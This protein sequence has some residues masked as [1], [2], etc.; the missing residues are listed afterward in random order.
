[1]VCPDRNVNEVGQSSNPY[2]LLNCLP[3]AVYNND[4]RT[5]DYAGETLTCEGDLVPEITIQNYG[6]ITLTTLSIEVSVNG[7]PVSTTPWSGN[8]TTYATDNITLPVL[9]G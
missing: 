5:F 3:P 2:S 1:M 6:L 4:V 7:S 8:L 9:T